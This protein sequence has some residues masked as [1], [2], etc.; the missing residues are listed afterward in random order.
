MF[1]NKL[2]DATCHLVDP[3]GSAVI[4]TAPYAEAVSIGEKDMPV[5]VS[6]GDT[7]EGL[8]TPLSNPPA[9]GLPPGNNPS[10]TL[11][12][13]FPSLLS[14]MGSLGIPNSENR[15]RHYKSPI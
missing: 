9:M 4:F 12:L 3:C 5:T 7:I 15:N 1:V 11:T 6:A 14:I 13:Y 2:F 10:N 8:Y